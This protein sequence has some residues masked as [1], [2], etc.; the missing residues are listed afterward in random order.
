MARMTRMDGWHGWRGRG[1]R[2]CRRDAGSVAGA[3]GAW[4]SGV[5]F[6]MGADTLLPQPL[7]HDHGLYAASPSGKCRGLRKVPGTGSV[8]PESAGTA[9]SPRHWQR[10]PESAGDRG[11][12]PALRA[13]VRKVPGIRKSPALTTNPGKCRGLRK[14]PGTESVPGTDSVPGTWTGALYEMGKTAVFILLPR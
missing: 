1:G 9:E 10:P 6:R 8:P 11:K 14:V 12:S 5:H 13:S 2:G 7:A 4:S 3:E